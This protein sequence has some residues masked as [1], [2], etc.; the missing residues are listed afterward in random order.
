M[1]GG[2]GGWVDVGFFSDIFFLREMM[3]NLNVFSFGKGR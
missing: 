2:Y 1:M 3:Q